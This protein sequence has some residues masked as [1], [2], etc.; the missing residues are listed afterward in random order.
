MTLSLQVALT[1]IVLFIFLR[2][3]IRSWF[4]DESSNFSI[5]TYKKVTTWFGF[6]IAL[7]IISIIVAAI[8]LIWF[9]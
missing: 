8:D 9:N 4:I 5:E 1:L 7:M 3:M 6:Y 2:F